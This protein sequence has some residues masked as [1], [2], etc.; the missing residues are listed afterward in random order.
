MTANAY[1]HCGETGIGPF[2]WGN[3]TVDV[4]VLGPFSVSESGRAIT[5]KAA[6][7]RALL[8]LLALSGA[9]V[10]PAPALIGEIWPDR[11]PRSAVT[12]LQ[13]YIVSL[14]RSIANVCGADPKR[15]LR[16]ARGGYLLDL[17][18]GTL[19]VAAFQQWLQAGRESM[20]R[21]DYRT[22]LSHFDKCLALWRGDPLADVI[23]GPRLAVEITRLEGCRLSL[24]DW[25][26]ECGLMLGRHRE[27]L[28][29]LAGLTMQYPL[30]ETL[31]GQYMLALCRAGRRSQALDV[32]QRLRLE[33]DTALGMA[34][35]PVLQRLQRA[36]LSA[37]PALESERTTLETFRAAMAG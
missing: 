3:S 21:E 25:H 19:D 26:I 15:V 9:Q 17:G 11:P 16:T 6:K 27:L 7:P 30:H 8:A 4:Y 29:E 22:A 18:G 32:F 13:T 37:D 36:V 1:F 28:G 2:A 31:H 33:L 10:V 34:P 12:T 23:A 24:T 20:R 14:R 35:S 5:P